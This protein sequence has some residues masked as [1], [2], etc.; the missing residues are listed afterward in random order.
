MMYANYSSRLPK[1]SLLCIDSPSGLSRPIIIAVPSGCDPECNPACAA[2]RCS[3]R[4]WSFSSRGLPCRGGRRAAAAG[5]P[6]QRVRRPVGGRRRGHGDYRGERRGAL[7]Q[8]HGLRAQ[9][10]ADV[11]R[12]AVGLLAPGQPSRGRRRNP[13]GGPRPGAAVCGLHPGPALAQSRIRHPGRTD[14]PDVRRLRPTG[15][16]G[17][18]QSPH[19]LSARLSVPDLASSR[20]R[21]RDGGRPARHARPGLASY[22]P[23]R[24]RRTPGPGVPLISAFRWDTGIQ[25]HWEGRGA[26]RHGSVTTG[27]LADPRVSDNNGGKQVS[28]RLAYR[29]DGRARRSARRRPAASSSIAT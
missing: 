22:L 13:V 10:A 24:R 25:A 2:S 1:R 16:S 8:L 17:R 26:R 20:C 4:Q 27:T 12:R 15:L 23:H 19:R 5:R 7:L 3:S 28:G 21:A 9:H 18:R 29:P 14:S 6:G 11:P